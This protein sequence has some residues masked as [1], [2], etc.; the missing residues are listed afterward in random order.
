MRAP[1]TLDTIGSSGA[2]NSIVPAKAR[3]SSSIASMCAEW[4]AWLT[5]SLLVLRACAS[6]C[7]AISRTAS[8]SPETTTA[9]GPLSAAMD[10][11]VRSRGRTSS[12][13][14]WSETIAPPPGRACISR[15]R[16]ATSAA[17]SSRDSTPAAWAA[18][19]SPMEWPSR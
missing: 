14:A 15:P 5:R 6:K 2:L 18:D 3:N 19:S 7:A 4:N 1:V 17:A 10:T 16:A 13:V 8:S 11:P 9:R 12:S